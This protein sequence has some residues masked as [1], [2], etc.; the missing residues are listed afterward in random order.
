MFKK[1]YKLWFK[2]VSMKTFNFS[3]KI[4]KAHFVDSEL[5][6]LIFFSIDFTTEEY[7]E[8]YR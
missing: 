6:N 3:W 7:D 1:N 2:G 4:M 5:F 8:Y